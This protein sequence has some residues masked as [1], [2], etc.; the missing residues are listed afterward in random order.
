MT[1][2]SEREVSLTKFIGPGILFAASAV[3]VSHLVQSTRAGAMYGFAMLIFALLGLLA[4]Y[5][6]FLFAPS[7][8]AATGKSI[9]S[10]Y[11]NQGVFA[12][13][14]FAASTLVNMFTGISANLL[15]T[16]G[17]VKATLGLSIGIVPICVGI[18]IVG[19]GL[20]IIGHYRWLDI[21]T[22]FLMMF[23]TLTTIIATFFA[24]PL[25][26]W[27][28]SL[29][30]FPAQFEL[31]TILFIAA[32]IG[33]MPT[34]FDVSVWQSQWV[35]ANSRK[36]GY[37]PSQK[38][39]R[40]DFNVG[41]IGITVLAICF[42]ILG[43][44]VMHG[45]GESFASSPAGFAAQL[46]KLY[47]NVLGP[48]SGFII[49]VSA[50]AVMFSTMLTILDGFP[51][52][53]ANLVMIIFHKEESIDE[54]ESNESKRHTYYWVTMLI[55]ILGGLLILSVFLNR[56]KTFIDIGATI[57]FLSAPIFA[58]LNHR[59][60]NSEEIA[61]ENRPSKALYWW[62]VSGISGLACFALTYLYLVVF[63]V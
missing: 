21:V 50:F 15:V 18:C 19:G 25:I 16:S 29:V 62:S 14:F 55:M 22:K 23:L 2:N 10:S 58:F 48:W 45:S 4:K 44:A 24:L 47:E 42:M 51:R 1:G 49:G 9:L 34:P 63:V 41:Y 17:L 60:M 46:I 5:P 40:F 57:S 7:Y 59:A 26:D 30:F 6:A 56:L 12:L 20:L 36:N 27:G 11:R 43:T 3:G 53:T 13:L 8:A 33:W 52:S 39:A 28:K 32:L 54:G 35:V 37:L 38:Q 61:I 31:A